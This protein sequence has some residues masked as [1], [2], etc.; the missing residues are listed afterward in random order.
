MLRKFAI[1]V[2]IL[3]ASFYFI[4]FFQNKFENKQTENI[5][6]E[7]ENNQAIVVKN[8]P[9]PAAKQITLEEIQEK[10]D[11]IS[12]Q[13]DILAHEV[14][15]LSSFRQIAGAEIEIT[16]SPLDATSTKAKEDEEKINDEIEKLFKKIPETQ[17]IEPKIC[18]KDSW[19]FPARNKV[20]INELA[21]AGSFESANS[22]WLEL[23]NVSSQN[24]NL[25]G[26][27]I[28]NNSEQIKIIFGQ[29]DAISGG[30]FYLLERTDDQT[31]PSLPADKI[32]NGA[33]KNEGDFIYVFDENCQ[34]QDIVDGISGW[35]GGDNNSKRTLERKADFSWQTSLNSGGT[36][37][38]ENSSG[39][40]QPISSGGGFVAKTQK[41]VYL[42]ILISEIQI[43]SQE[44]AKDDFVELFN[45]NNTDVD[46]TDWYLQ[47]KTATGDDFSTY[48]SSKQFAQKIIKAKDYFLLV[49]A[50]SGLSL[51]AQATTTNPLT[52]DNTLVLKNPNGDVSDLVGFGNAKDFEAGPA[53]NP[54][55]TSTI[56]REWSSSTENYLDTDNNYDD[57]KIQTPTPGWLNKIF[58][59]ENPTSSP[60]TSTEDMPEPEPATTTL[61][62][63]YGTVV[64]N[65]IAWMGNASSS[66]NEWIELYN[67]SGEEIN[68]ADWTLAW[69]HGT[70]T[71][72]ASSGQTVIS[73]GGFYLLER[74]AGDTLP[75]IQEDRIYT[76]ALKND[77]EK[78]E[79]R[80]S[81]EN[82]IDFV[83]CS[84]SW[85]AGNNETKETMERKNPLL[86]GNDANNWASSTAPAGTPKAKNS[87]SF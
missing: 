57:F 69:S 51:L 15:Q 11:D 29:T 80:D 31:L 10:L 18:A 73:G 59:I 4:L 61:P 2:F 82:L 45:P 53:L 38:R 39:Y 58:E 79:L 78:L 16:E 87:V 25:V 64:I 66:N 63:P 6:K 72:A 26:W 12:E 60:A 84:L 46:L 3:G 5:V 37:K 27:Q 35:P 65:E 86:S 24:V 47:R 19:I 48:F 7:T 40:F 44:S 68:L 85:F 23:K 56:G 34:L 74:T 33:L 50:S 21:W 41:P 14:A 70:T 20:I 13:I 81:Q 49:N 52:E 77:G 55:A 28:L 76:G 17:I 30:S 71:F 32:Y 9:L 62:V 83:G 1:F 8:D 22:E 54:T 43:A 75:D 36:P 67:N 42:K